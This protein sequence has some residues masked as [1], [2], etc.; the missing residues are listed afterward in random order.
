MRLCWVQVCE[1]LVWHLGIQGTFLSSGGVV[2]VVMLLGASFAQ[3]WT[4][5]S[6]SNCWHFGIHS[7]FSECG[8]GGGGGDDDVV[9][10]DCSWVQV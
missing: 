7:A 5:W 9:R 3:I 6:L 10:W 1:Q 8:C 4:S 2:V